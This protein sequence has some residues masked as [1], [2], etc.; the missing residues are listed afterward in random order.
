M[1]CPNTCAE[2]NL[3]PVN[4]KFEIND[5]V[6]WPAPNGKT[7]RGTIKEISYCTVVISNSYSVLFDDGRTMGFVTEDKHN[8]LKLVGKERTLIDF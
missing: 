5:R 3:P 8:Q 2:C 7:Y 4:P 6:D 1:S